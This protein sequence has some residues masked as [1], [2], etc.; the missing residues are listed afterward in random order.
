MGESGNVG[1]GGNCV[2]LEDEIAQTASMRKAR[3]IANVRMEDEENLEIGDVAQPIEVD[4]VLLEDAILRPAIDIVS[5]VIVRCSKL[6]DKSGY[7]LV[8]S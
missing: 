5:I 8:L 2:R 7:F 6:W 1:D 3:R 4:D